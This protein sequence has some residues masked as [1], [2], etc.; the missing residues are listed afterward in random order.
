MM[1]VTSGRR[2]VVL[3]DP[4]GDA[5]SALR[6]APPLGARPTRL[7]LLVAGTSR[8]R[9]ELRLAQSLGAR[10]FEETEDRV[11]EERGGEARGASAVA[12]PVAGQALLLASDGFPWSVG[13]PAG[14]PS[15]EMV[16]V[17]EARAR[18]LDPSLATRPARKLRLRDPARSGAVDRSSGSRSGFLGRSGDRSGLGERILSLRPED[19]E[20]LR[21]GHAN[22][23]W[24]WI[25]APR[26]LPQ[27]LPPDGARLLRNLGTELEPVLV[28]CDREPR[29]R[30]QASRIRRVF[31]VPEGSGLVWWDREDGERHI[32]F[33]RAGLARID[34]DL[35]RTLIG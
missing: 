17:L 29:P 31:D 1:S 24:W 28:P 18:P 22:D 19:I 21:L 7:G 12:Q 30:I 4:A 20:E 33:H 35:A 8:S 13:D 27:S 9:E 25:Y 11:F 26:G 3:L 5:L 2:V 16:L 23:G 6:L 14:W 32:V 15:L 34:P 10:V